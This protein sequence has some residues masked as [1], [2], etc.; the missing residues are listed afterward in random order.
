MANPTVVSWVKRA[1]RTTGADP[2]ALL[3]TALQESGARLGA[4]GDQGTSFGPFQFHVGGALG[5]HPPAWANTYPAALNR[6]SEFSRLGVHGGRGAAAVQRPADPSGYAAGVN[7]KLAEARALL[8]GAGGTPPASS[9]EG[10]ALGPANAAVTGGVGRSTPDAAQ[11]ALIQSLLDQ[12]AQLA[13]I[14]G[15]TLPAPPATAAAPATTAAPIPRVPAPTTAGYPLA[16]H[17][18]IIGL[19]HQGT[20]TLYGN[21]ESDDAVDI[22]AKVGTPVYAPFDGVIG[23]Q[24]GALDSRDPHLQGLRVHVDGA[25]DSAYLAHLSRLVVKAGEHVRKGQIIGY[26]GEANGVAHLHF[27]TEHRDPRTYLA[28]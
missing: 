3:A 2:V 23:P 18:K 24:I 6:A 26:S 10:R 12:N 27:A 9:R 5:S 21:W 8:S 4:V 22:A 1:A 19:P 25:K 14:P 15:I 17:G 13:H 16:A 20:H 28:S 7:A 11:V